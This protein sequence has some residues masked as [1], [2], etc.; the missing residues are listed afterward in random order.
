MERMQAWPISAEAKPSDG[1]C[2]CDHKLLNVSMATATSWRVKLQSAPVFT[3][4]P[5]E[6][7]S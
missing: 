7:M 6:V 4:P 2:S 3:S 1:C 5:T